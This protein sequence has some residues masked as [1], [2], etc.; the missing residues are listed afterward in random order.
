[1][2]AIR[3]WS[4][5]ALCACGDAASQTSEPA[6]PPKAV[7]PKKLDEALASIVATCARCDGAVEV[8]RKGKPYWEPIA[9][10][11]TFR[12]GDWI[13]TG[14]SGSARIRFVSGGH[15]DLDE[16]T[17]LFVEADGSK[18]VGDNAT[19]VHVAMQT[20]AASGQVDGATDAP[21]RIRTSEG[22]VRIEGA[23][24]S[25]FRL[26]PADDG[27]VELAVSKGELRVKSDAS[28]RRMVPETV[29][30]AVERKP[31]VA[32]KPVARPF[33][34]KPRVSPIAYPQSVAPAIDAR[35]TCTGQNIPLRWN[36]VTG[37]AKYRVVVAKDMSF[38]SVVMR[39]EL[40]TTEVAF[41]P[42][43]RGQY[44]WRV[45]A[46]DARGYG[47]FGFARRIFCK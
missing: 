11:G 44:V 29:E 20:G 43:A 32:D 46:R 2:V 4:V 18:R 38:R 37:A 33:R 36:K 12:D 28:E 22:D 34:P 30:P 26:K 8:R 16:K 35:F 25:E 45:A 40:A 27:T 6:E 15:L 21:I 5:L 13:R 41:A 19:G 42:K 23:G 1:M 10:G 47:E 17:T 7:V 14:S 31:P 9:M 24:A 39:K 3:L